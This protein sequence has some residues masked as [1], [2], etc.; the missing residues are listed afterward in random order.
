VFYPAVRRAK[1]RHLG[2]KALQHSHASA[3]LLAGAPIT[4]VQHIVSGT[5]ARP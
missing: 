1:L 2:L 5:R 3:L 4:Y